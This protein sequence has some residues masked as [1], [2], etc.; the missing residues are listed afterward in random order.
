MD[1]ITQILKNVVRCKYFEAG[2]QIKNPIK[3]S[4]KDG[5]G[6]TTQTLDHVVL[7]HILIWDKKKSQIIEY[8]ECQQLIHDILSTLFMHFLRHQQYGIMKPSCSNLKA[9]AEFGA[10]IWCWN[11]KSLKHFLLVSFEPPSCK[12]VSERENWLMSSG[13]NGYLLQ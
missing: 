9:T 8:S 5:L 10:I 2:V 1:K 7:V 3:N 13:Q 11:V 6:R 4:Y 12:C